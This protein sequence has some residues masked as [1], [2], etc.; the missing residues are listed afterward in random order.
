MLEM[1]ERVSLRYAYIDNVLAFRMA[2]AS[3]RACAGWHSSDDDLVYISSTSREIEGLLGIF[4][5]SG[6]FSLED[7]HALCNC[8]L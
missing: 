3:V 4:G 8:S 2:F 1:V 7:K 6:G 5:S